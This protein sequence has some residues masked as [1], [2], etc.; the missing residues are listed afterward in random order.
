M[1]GGIYPYTANAIDPYARGQV[2][3]QDSDA[4]GLFDPVD[5][6]PEMTITSTAQLENQWTVT[7]RAVD[8]PFPSP[9]RPAATINEVRVEYR[10]DGGDWTTATPADGAFDSPEESFSLTLEPAA[11][12]NHHLDVRARNS[13][14]NT[15]EWISSIIVLPDPIDGGLDTRLEPPLAGL[16]GGASPHDIRGVASSFNADGTPGAAIQRVEYRIDS[17]RWQM[18][19]AED[20]SFN[21]VEESFTLTVALLG[22]V[23]LIEARAVDVNGR[24]EQNM[25]RLELSINHT[26]FLPALQR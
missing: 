12:G 26:V 2:G 8:R 10:L 24:T 3:W 21:D 20:G 15:S 13:V 25:A 6:I 23:H 16:P 14:G 9:L 22:G 19:Q 1:R 11:S 4:D 5:T 7:G 18:A 17:G